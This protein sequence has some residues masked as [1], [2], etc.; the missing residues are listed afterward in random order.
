MSFSCAV[1]ASQQ[2]PARRHFRIVIG[3]IR[4]DIN[5]TLL[6]LGE[7]ATVRYRGKGTAHKILVVAQQTI[8]DFKS[9]EGFI[10]EGAQ[11][12][13]LAQALSATSLDLICLPDTY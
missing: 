10:G 2:K 6:F 5:I 9:S 1:G 8:F 4:R 11:I 13:Q 12:A 7:V 3:T